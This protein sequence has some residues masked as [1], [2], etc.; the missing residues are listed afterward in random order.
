MDEKWKPIIS[1]ICYDDG[2]LIHVYTYYI[3]GLTL[4]GDIPKYNLHSM[5]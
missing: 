2:I 3:Q 5:R 4:N 1:S